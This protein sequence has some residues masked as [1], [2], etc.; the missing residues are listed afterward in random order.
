MNCNGARIYFT[1]T[2]LFCFA[3]LLMSLSLKLVIIRKLVTPV[4]WILY[5]GQFWGPSQNT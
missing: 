4:L 5:N 3:C 2:S 1:L